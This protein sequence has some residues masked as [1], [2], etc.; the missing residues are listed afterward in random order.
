M[1]FQHNLSKQITKGKKFMSKKMKKLFCIVLSIIMLMG[2]VPFSVFALD[3][4]SV[5]IENNIELNGSSTF[6]SM[7]ADAISEE[8]NICSDYSVTAIDVTN[9]EATVTYN[10][11]SDCTLLLAFYDEQTNE[12]YSYYSAEV[13]EYDVTVTISLNSDDLPNYYIAKA[14]LVDNKGAALCKEYVSYIY[15]KAFED[16]FTNTTVYDFDE[17]KVINL[18]D[19]YVTNFAVIADTTKKITSDGT[20]NIIENSYYDGDTYTF[21][22]I[23]SDISSLNAG[24]VFWYYTGDNEDVIIIKIKTID[25]DGST[26]VITADET[27]LDEVFDF[28]KI[29][30][31]NDEYKMY[32]SPYYDESDENLDEVAETSKS[33]KSMQKAKV[34]FDESKSISATYPFGKDGKGWNVS[35]NVKVKGSVSFTVGATV[36]VYYKS[37]W[38]KDNYLQVEVSVSPKFKIDISLNAEM[39]DKKV[40]KIG[41]VSVPLCAGLYVEFTPAIAIKASAKIDISG[42]LTVKAG[43]EYNNIDGFVNKCESPSFKPEIKVEGEFF[44]GLDMTP[45]VCIVHEKVADAGITAEAGFEIKAETKAKSDTHS[46]Y[47]CLDGD[48]NLNGEVSAYVQFLNKFKPSAKIINFS[49]KIADFYYSVD[50]SLFG[51]GEC[52][53]DTD[54]ANQEFNGHYY[55]VFNGGTVSTWE[56]AKVYCENIGGHLAVIQSKEENMFLSDLIHSLGMKTAYFGYSDAKKE[57]QWE[58]VY[59]DSSYT[60]WHS[61][62]PNNDGGKENYAEFYWKWTD[63]T[64]NDGNFAKGTQADESAFICE[65]ESYRDYKKNKTQ[66]GM[67]GRKSAPAK[68]T[69]Q[70]N[71]SQELID[72]S[73][74]E[75]SISFTAEPQSIYMVY[76]VADNNDIKYI[77]QG[78]ADNSGFVNTT[79]YENADTDT[80]A[81]GYFEN[82]IASIKLNISD[83]THSYNKNITSPDCLSDGNIVY[84]CSCGDSYTE[85]IPATGHIDDNGDGYCDKCHI[86]LSVH[87]SDDPSA[88]C[89]CNHHKSGIIKFFWKIL[90]FFHKLFGMKQYQYCACGEAHW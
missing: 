38:F 21:T 43:F 3:A 16:N 39:P 74:F 18:D 50:H 42:T 10:T 29:D 34:D 4:D 77:S 87:E 46:C 88:N 64:W 76:S 82:Q 70:N 75:Y 33:S 56:D 72:A 60:N 49:E 45:H 26:A 68:V 80:Y 47:V 9:S 35:E 51:W 52:P 24:D 37:H 41:E 15:T 63:G 86:D 67:G 19:S 1:I 12:M 13:D 48:I 2:C 55:K 36:K 71:M 89:S 40:K 17:N 85:I 81:V 22:D 6:G 32:F 23:T 73:Y 14:Y 59:G 66:G 5:S 69:A 31:S 57:G 8:A 65:W 30:E 83:H 28:V 25:V 7:L 79:F 54:S 11:I 20:S 27:S 61:G 84:T 90:N 44:V 78:T 58:W 62:E 53:F